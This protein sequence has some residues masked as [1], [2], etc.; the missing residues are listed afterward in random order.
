ME[1]TAEVAQISSSEIWQNLKDNWINIAIIVGA[2]IIVII[3][4]KL[5][6]R[7]LRRLFEKKISDEKLYIKKRTYTFTSVLSN[8]IVVVSIVTGALIIADMAGISITPLLAGAGV[9]GIIIGLGAQSLIKDLINGMF[10]L[11]EQWFQV[12]DIVK[13]GDITGTVERLNLRTT[14]LR[15]LEGNVHYIPNGEISMLSNMTQLWARALVEIGVHYDE[16]ID[17]VVSILED[18][19]DEIVKDKKYK[20]VIL[21]RPSILGDGGINELGDSA[22]TFKIICKV[23][24]GEQWTISRQLRKRIKEKFDLKGIEIP[25][26]CTNV[27]MRSN[28]TETEK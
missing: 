17:N 13:V 10:I 28:G 8:L 18:V 23:K 21:E 6:S 1:E 24:P 22:V 14:V 26:P 2:V 3:I 7:R 4:V 11:F 19:F 15:D 27:Y 20:K 25:Y 5:V 9:A 16:N 12:N